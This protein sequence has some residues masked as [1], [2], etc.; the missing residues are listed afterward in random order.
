MARFKVG[1]WVVIV[2]KRPE[3]NGKYDGLVCR[4][5]DMNGEDYILENAKL[6]V[7]SMWSEEFLLPAIEVIKVGSRLK[8]R[9]D[10]SETMETRPMFGLN[11]YMRQK[12]GVI[13]TVK[14]RSVVRDRDYDYSDNL[15][16][17]LEKDIFL[18][19]WSLAMFERVID[20]DYKVENNMEEEKEMEEKIVL[21]PEQ[22]QQLVDEMR[23]LLDEYDYNYSDSAIDK[24]IDEWF[25]A[26]EPIIRILSKHPNWNPDKFQVQF[27]HT[28][29]RIL[30][31]K[32]RLSF[33]AWIR[34]GDLLTTLLETQVIDGKTLTELENELYG[35]R[36]KKPVYKDGVAFNK[37]LYISSIKK[38]V[39]IQTRISAFNNQRYTKESVDK[40]RSS[41]KIYDILI[42]CTEQYISQEDA[43]E[44][45]KI[46]SEL[47]VHRGHKTTK[48]VGKFCRMYGID[49]ADNYGREYAKY[50]DAMN[51]LQINRH[52]VLSVNPIDYL[53]MSFGNTWS[54]CHTIDKDNIRQR[55]G[56]S[57][58][59]CYSSGTMSYLLDETSIVFY[60]VDSDY[61]GSDFELE[62][63]ISRNMFHFGEEKL[64]QGRIYPFDQTD[65]DHSCGNEIYKPYREI[66]QKIFAECLEVPNLWYN[67]KGTE[68]CD[69]VTYHTGTHYRDII[70]YGNCNVSY[71]R[72]TPTDTDFNDVKICIG[73]K[74]ICIKCGSRHTVEDNISCCDSG[75]KCIHCGEHIS[76]GDIDR[77]FARYT[78]DGWCCD[79][80]DCAVWCEYH[81]R[82]EEND[83][84]HEYVEEYGWVC[85]TGINNSYNLNYC[86]NCG[87]VFH[88]DDG[89]FD[90]H[91]DYYCDS[92]SENNLVYVDSEGEYYPEN[93][94]ARCASCEE[95]FLRTDMKMD[96]FGD[97][98]CEGCWEEIYGEEENT[99]ESA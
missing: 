72:K 77:G 21:T 5:V 6:V 36:I 96:D 45:N 39:E 24:I 30:D 61:N 93:E 52:T 87:R 67:K 57:Y 20:A 23:D 32:G 76:Q 3:M 62:D 22:K 60:T 51:P 33:F 26:K 9:E 35:M 79:D 12:K 59:G 1:D 15:C 90:A 97:Y 37:E 50:A 83:T 43:D 56:R 73:A 49:K 74:P 17:Y 18:W 99:E 78:E 80:D 68:E 44:L 91:G 11:D 40:Y 69:K 8:I 7:K 86:E 63:K 95:Y 10:L 98:Y 34:N 27:N 66:V 41:C 92:C 29:N 4:I 81:E 89:I 2:D 25:K 42:D 46:D 53:T 75:E 54:S 19:T 13:V 84:S 38:K 28:F 65:D 82:Y 31:K 88:T 47:R 94:V 14:K 55:G 58:Q 70:H 64:I 16:L 85:E 48:I 71:L